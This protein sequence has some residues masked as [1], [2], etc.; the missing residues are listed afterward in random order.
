MKKA[1]G[2][3]GPRAFLLKCHSRL[4]A[5]VII[6]NVLNEGPPRDSTFDQYP[7]FSTGNYDPYGRE[8]FLQVSYKFK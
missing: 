5:S 7:Y 2:P 6:N 3:N 4:S 8:G 1:L